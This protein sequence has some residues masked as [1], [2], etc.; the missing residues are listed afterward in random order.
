MKFYDWMTR[1]P[2][3]R[4]YLAKILAVCFVGVHIPM[5]GAVTYIL[6]A[7]D[8]HLADTIGILVAMLVATL[9]GTVSSMAMLYYLLIPVSQAAGALRA[10]LEHRQIPSLPTRY[11]DEAGV[12]LANVQ[13]TVTRLD[14]ALDTARA[15]REEALQGRRS[16][17]QVLAGMSHD[18]RTP[19]NHV[20]GFAELM[21]TEALGPLG[22]RQYRDYAT[23]IR[24]SGEDLLATL[25]TLLELSAQEADTGADSSSPHAVD[26]AAAVDQ[27]VRLTHFQ[28][29]RRG[30]AFHL[31]TPSRYSPAVPVAER[32]LKQIILHTL[33]IAM[34]TADAAKNVRVSISA[35]DDTAELTIVGD[36]PWGNGDVPPELAAPHEAVEEDFPSSTATALRLSLVNSL[37]RASGGTLTVASDAGGDRSIALTLPRAAPALSPAQAA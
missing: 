35:Q 22:S 6:L 1:L 30:T 23:G 20:I 34:G 16:K 3:P 19:L 9:I 25:Q 4:Y 14:M 11:N 18:L 36:L 13:E 7:A 5:I 21:T 32:S 27:A 15:Q 17:F 24:D 31:T 37:V 29:D 28:A 26:L 8:I 10:Y 33:Q 12:L 2:L